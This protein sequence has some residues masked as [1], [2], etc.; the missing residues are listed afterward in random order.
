MTPNDQQTPQ[1]RNLCLPLQ[2]SGWWSSEWRPA[3]PGRD[4]KLQVGGLTGVAPDI[5]EAILDGRQPAELRVHVLREWFPVEWG[6][7]WRGCAT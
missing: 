5:V 6:V 4:I 3:Q 1:K 2:P 7:D